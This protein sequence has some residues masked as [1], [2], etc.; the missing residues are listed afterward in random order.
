MSQKYLNI[1][2]F[3][4]GVEPRDKALD[5][6]GTTEK[7][8]EQINRFEFPATF[9]IQYD[10]FINDDFLCVLNGIDRKKSEI[11]LWLEIVQPLVEAVGIKWRGRKGFSWDW[12]VNP[13]FLI[14]YTKEQKKLL[15]DKAFAIFKDKFGF[16]P[17]SVGSW[18]LDSFSMDYM[19]EKYSVKG[20]CICREQY[21]T[22]GYTLWGG[23]FNQGYYASK[24][25]FLVPAFDFKNA[26]KSPVFRMLGTDPI[27]EYDSK[28]D[29]DFN[30][31]DADT[32]YTMEP[33]WASGK[34]PKFIKWFLHTIFYNESLGNAYVQIG[35]ENSFGWENIYKGLEMQYKYLKTLKGV[36]ICTLSEASEKFKKSFS[37]NVSCAV[38]AI[39]DWKGNNNQSF[40]F[41]SKNYRANLYSDGKKIWFRDIRLYSDNIRDIYNNS[42]AVGN[43]AQYIIPPIVD[44][45]LW[46]GNSVRAGIYL[47]N[48]E[49]VLN[50]Q[51]NDTYTLNTNSGVSIKF[52]EKRIVISGEEQLNFVFYKTDDVNISSCGSKILYK[53]EDY[54]YYLETNGTVEQSYKGYVIKRT[55]ENITLQFG[56]L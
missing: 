13:G 8:I 52:F 43:T 6:I 22:D 31:V 12:H 36:N 16:Y 54:N 51:N 35:Q 29:S 37:E 1:I 27:Y 38:S 45:F 19:T 40:Y 24:N 28:L 32:I 47:N 3:V 7:Q 15:I 46:S 44:G 34:D 26:V 20:F 41:T 49:S 39:S 14:A 33:V 30:R 48:S 11:G 53:F 55:E 42:P 21:G 10:A 18:I 4:R 23:P 56:G 2:N 17:Y 25:N 5:L 9:L 50:I